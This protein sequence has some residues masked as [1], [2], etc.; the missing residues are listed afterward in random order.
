MER[1]VSSRSR[2]ARRRLLAFAGGV[3]AALTLA[4]ARLV[5]G[6]LFSEQPQLPPTLP[7]PSTINADASPEFRAV[8]ETLVAAMRRHQ[9][10]GAALGILAGDREE[11]ASFGVASVN[12]LQPVSPATLFQIGSLSKTYTAT[13]IWRLIDEGAFALDVPL[14]TFIPDLRL[15]D[16]A[17]AAK[18]TIANLLDHSA[19]WYSDDG[20]DTGSGDDALARYVDE[21]LPV[22]PQ[23]FPLGAFFSYNNTAFQLLGRLIEVATGSTYNAA[24]QSMLFDPL[25]LADTLLDHDAVLRR[26]FSEGHAIGPI[27]G[28]DAVAVQ[29]PLFVPRSADPAGGIWSTTRDVLRY[30]RLH[31]DADAL[32][33]RAR[34]VQPASLRQMQ[35]PA[36]AVPG[37]SLSMGR[38][39]FI[40]DVAG[41]RTIFHDGDTLGQHTAFVAVPEYNFAFI[42]LCNGQPGSLVAQLA[43]DE[44]LARYPGLGP[45]SGQVG[46]IRL[47]VALGD[48]PTVA[49]SSAALAAYTGH[50]VDPGQ[51]DTITATTDGLRR[52]V[53]LT[54][55][56]GTLQPAIAPPPPDPTPLSFLEP[57]LAVA[58]GL[59]L[60]F[61]RDSSGRV[62]W[63]ADGLRLRPRSDPT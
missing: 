52:M 31:L 55:E 16:D 19:G 2:I 26:P 35:V 43:L 45:L 39:W 61:V 63:V 32:P 1:Q 6:R 49:L 18:V 47:L 50:Y 58:G 13:V 3:T 41:V 10:P 34:V 4:P 38:N 8:A 5:A 29:S 42:L 51:T 59:K 14:R 20:F 30:A 27:N 28:H 54:P 60:P 25:G 44:A 7:L 9:I 22:L 21:R 37:L 23:L 36:K 40:Q 11:H 48:Q 33:G 53:D 17:T 12:S 24:M 57:D 46:L 56:P 15:S 62:G